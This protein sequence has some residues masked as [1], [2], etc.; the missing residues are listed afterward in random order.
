MTS[1]VLFCGIPKEELEESLP[2]ESGCPFSQQCQSILF[3]SQTSLQSLETK[4]TGVISSTFRSRW[5]KHVRGAG[6]VGCFAGC[7]R[8]C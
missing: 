8:E 2:S 7:C 4:I 3:I 5:R 6:G 1:Q